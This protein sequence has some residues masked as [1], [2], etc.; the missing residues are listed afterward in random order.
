VH[1][2]ELAEEQTD[3]ARTDA[4]LQGLSLHPCAR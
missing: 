4:L 3:R 1:E 2:S